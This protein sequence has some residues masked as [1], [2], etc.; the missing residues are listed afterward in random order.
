MK[1]T[2]GNAKVGK[3]VRVFGEYRY[4][5]NGTDGYGDDTALHQYTTCEGC[6]TKLISW[7]KYADCPKCGKVCYLT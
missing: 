6:N 4:I 7:S 3:R 2:K 5:A 1:L